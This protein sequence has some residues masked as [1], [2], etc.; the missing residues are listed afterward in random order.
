MRTALKRIISFAIVLALGGCTAIADLDRFESEGDTGRVACDM[1]L[2]LEGFVPHVGQL[3]DVR[4]Q[5]LAD[6]R[7]RARAIFNPLDLPNMQMV[8]PNAVPTGGQSI[9][10]FADANGSGMPDPIPTDHAWRIFNPCDSAPNNFP[11]NFDFVD[12]PMA[13]P[14]NRDLRM[15]FRGMTVNDGVFE[16]RVSQI[17]RPATADD[18]GDVRT[19]GVYRTTV[20]EADFNVAIP[21]IIPDG[22]IC[23][24]MPCLEVAFWQDGDGD[25]AYDAP[26]TDESW[27]LTVNPDRIETLAF[28]HIVE[29]VDIG[30]TLTSGTN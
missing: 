22:M 3:V 1:E 27:R 30:F 12:L 28:E 21:H 19:I 7:V 18:A 20:T 2:R 25:G 10:F 9:D 16:L 11:H 14:G 26:P 15:S 13:A 24:D 23:G 4:V 8:M 6:Q 5:S 17:I 29:Y